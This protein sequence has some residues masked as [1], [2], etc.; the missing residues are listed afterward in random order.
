MLNQLQGVFASFQKHQVRYVVIGGIAAVLHG[1]P[2]ATFDLIFLSKPRLI[3]P[4]ASWM[5]FWRQTWGL[6]R[7]PQPMNCWPTKLQ[8]L[9][10]G[11]GLTYKRLRRAYFLS[12]PGK[13][14]K[15][16]LITTKS[17]MLFP[18]LI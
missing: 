4:N 2:R 7:L 11:F 9:T 6:R 14:E 1:V 5:R 12:K 15:R 13:I 16:W 3:M 8:S 17:S 10:I 18:E